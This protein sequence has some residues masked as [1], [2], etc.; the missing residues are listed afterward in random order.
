[1]F[2]PSKETLPLFGKNK[3]LPQGLKL[4][5]V[6]KKHLQSGLQPFFRIGAHNSI[7]RGE[8]MVK[9]PQLPIYFGPSKR[10]WL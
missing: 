1:M 4:T 10:P 6:E 3:K 7:Y 2:I 5:H 8:K 9:N